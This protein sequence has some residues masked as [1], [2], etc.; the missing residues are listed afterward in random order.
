[1]LGTDLKKWNI[2]MMEHKLDLV[3]TKVVGFL[4]QKLPKAT[5]LWQFT[6]FL[7]QQLPIMMPQFVLQVHQRRQNSAKGSAIN[8]EI[9]Y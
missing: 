4:A 9:F 5:H 7:K 6:A 3:E 1:M 2:Y 8:F